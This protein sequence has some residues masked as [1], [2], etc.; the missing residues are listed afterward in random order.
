M[1]IKKV[2][3]GVR[4]QFSHKEYEKLLAALDLAEHSID[5]SPGKA[6]R[7][8]QTFLEAFQRADEWPVE[9]F[10]ARQGRERVIHAR[11]R[12]LQKFEEGTR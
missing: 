9:T 2:K 11:G 4:A 10:R 8:V 5:S 3:S 1:K 6:Y 12:G 7:D